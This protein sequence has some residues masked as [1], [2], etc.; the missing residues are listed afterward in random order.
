MLM[1]TYYQLICKE[2]TYRY[3]KEH[4]AK[5]Y[6]W[7]LRNPP[8]NI[9]KTKSQTPVPRKSFHNVKL[10]VILFKHIVTSRS[11]KRRFAT[12]KNRPIPTWF[13]TQFERY[14]D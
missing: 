9:N 13:K 5:D 3:G 12:W 14:Y 11:C 6:W 10:R 1:F 7:L 2:Y 8:M 4:G